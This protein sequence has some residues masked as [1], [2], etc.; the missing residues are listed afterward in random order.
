MLYSRLKNH[1]EAYKHSVT[2]YSVNGAVP[3]CALT[4]ERRT[5]LGNSLAGCDPAAGAVIR[6]TGQARHILLIDDNY[7]LAFNFFHRRPAPH[8][9]HRRCPISAPVSG[10]G[11][12]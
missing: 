1:A 12:G 9:V 8:N 6:I 10:P 11:C 7:I 2:R 3:R 4:R 5:A